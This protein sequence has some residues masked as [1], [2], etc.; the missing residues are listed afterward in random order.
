MSSLVLG[1]G[2]S[3]KATRAGVARL[4]EEVVT[5]ANSPIESVAV[6]ATRS[7]FVADERLQLGM[8]IV[9]IDDEDL[10]ALWGAPRPAGFAARVA[11]GCAMIGAGERARL[12]VAPRRGTFVTVALAQRTDSSDQ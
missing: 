4:V 12:L 6:L 2:M 10:L 1:V 5:M 11:E 3:S 8:M 9:G 7:K